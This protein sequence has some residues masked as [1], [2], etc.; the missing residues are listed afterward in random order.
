MS[1]PFSVAVVGA[2]FSG[3]CAGIKLKEAGID[4]T[5]FEKAE[6][7]GGTW[8]DNTYPG[9][10]C[11]IP[12]HLYSFSFERNPGWSKA[13]SPWHEI[14]DYVERCVDRYGLRPHLRLGTEVTK[15]AFDEERGVWELTLNDGSVETARAVMFGTGPLSVPSIPELEGLARFE[16]A[17][18]HSSRWDH[19][20][21]FAGKRVAVVGTGASAIQIVP[22]LQPVAE[23]LT[24]FQRTPPWVLPKPDTVYS[25]TAKRLFARFPALTRAY[26]NTIY[27]VLEA[28][29]AGFVVDPRINQARRGMAIRHIESAIDDPALREK[30]TPDYMI[31]CKRVLLS[32]DYYPALAQPNVELVDR[33]VREVTERGVID[34]DGREHPVDAIVWSTGFEVTAMLGDIEVKGI[35]GADLKELW[36]RRSIQA[37]YGIVVSG[38][39]N[40]YI[41]VG[42]NTGLGH[43][44]VVFMIEAQVHYAMR[45]IEQLRERDLRYLDVK[46]GA[47]N[48]F[49]ERLQERLAD[50]VWATGCQSWYLADGGRNSTLWPGFTF[51]YWLRTRRVNRG[52]FASVPS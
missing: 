49:N 35:G 23:K 48:L 24:L 20:Y 6:R 11:D 5:I 17:S 7:V 32:N 42:P 9:C 33:A 37:F 3:V 16:G 39:P 28:L 34:A 27:W 29:G 38:F 46:R 50:T 52:D 30:V 4:F 8:R 44:S 14:L 51:E 41:L 40:A 25:E 36:R 47:Q 31:G 19:D 18:F 1:D 22:N 26:R 10:E 45:C 12:S 15:A 2:G 43:N 13:F 21:D